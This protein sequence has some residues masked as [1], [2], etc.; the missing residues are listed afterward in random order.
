MPTESSGTLIQLPTGSRIPKP[1]PN[2]KQS[3]VES[4]VG[5]GVVPSP[6]P[7]TGEESP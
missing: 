5:D 4:A 6:G 7:H 3:A 2:K 1:L